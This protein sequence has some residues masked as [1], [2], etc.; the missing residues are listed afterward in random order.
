LGFGGGF[1]FPPD[2]RPVVGDQRGHGCVDLSGDALVVLC[3]PTSALGVLAEDR[4]G[5]VVDQGRVAIMRQ[6]P[7][8]D[9]LEHGDRG[10]GNP[11]GGARV[12][13]DDPVGEVLVQPIEGLLEGADLR[14]ANLFQA[15][16]AGARANEYAK[17]PTGFD[18]EAA[19]VIFQ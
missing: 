18:P 17:W 11:L 6:A 10:L 3:D 7:V 1:D 5:E 13:L 8:H 19:G 15:N 16:L 14:G 12:E 4:A 9:G 2:R